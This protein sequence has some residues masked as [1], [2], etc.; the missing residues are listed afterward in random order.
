M[1]RIK[2]NEK[3]IKILRSDDKICDVRDCGTVATFSMG[4]DVGSRKS[5]LPLCAYHYSCLLKG[6]LAY[7]NGIVF[8]LVPVKRVDKFSDEEID[9]SYNDIVFPRLSLVGDSASVKF[10]RGEIRFNVHRMLTRFFE[11]EETFY[12]SELL[13]IKTIFDELGIKYDIEWEV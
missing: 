2:Y 9:K 12:E 11:L 5:Y 1:A 7:E 4:W 8:E 10:G 3:Q 6:R 13:L